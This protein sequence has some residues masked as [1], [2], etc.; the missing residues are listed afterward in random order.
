MTTMM[1]IMNMTTTTMKRRR[2]RKKRRRTTK[3]R[4]PDRRNNIFQFSNVFCYIIKFNFGKSG[5]VENIFLIE[6]FIY[7]HS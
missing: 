1:M 2:K 3:M 7:I 5:L 6:Y 4:I